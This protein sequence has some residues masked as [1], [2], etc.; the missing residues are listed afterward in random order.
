MRYALLAI[1]AL[2]A[3]SVAAS[4]PGFAQTKSA[5]AKKSLQSSF[6]ACVSLARKR[7]YSSVDLHENRE[8]ARN[9]VIQCLQGTQK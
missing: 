8:A 5:E 6:N 1:G 2:L 9:F 7:G 4:S 3:V